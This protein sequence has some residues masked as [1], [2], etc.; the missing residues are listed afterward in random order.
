MKDS[1][2]KE[3]RRIE[4]H[5][6]TRCNN[7][8]VFCISSVNRD[9]KEDWA[10]PERVR[11]ELRYFYE[12]GCRAAGF[13]GGEPTVYSHI[14]ESIAYARRTALCLETEGFPDAPN[15]PAFPSAVLRP[16]QTYRHTLIHRFVL[17]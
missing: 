9:R 13:L 1:P 12:K 4:V 2:P 7:L 3:P 10:R 15:Q 14:V 11:A 8:C 6:G 16:G 17:E 5:L